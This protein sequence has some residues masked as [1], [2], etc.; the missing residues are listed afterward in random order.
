MIDAM[1][2]A[3]I[4]FFISY[5]SYR[6]Q[7]DIDTLSLGFSLVFSLMA[8]S[9]IQIYIQT[10]RID[11]SIVG[12][13]LL[14]FVVFLAFTLVFDVTCVACIPYESPYGVSYKTFRQ[15]RFWFANIFIIITAL[16]PRFTVKCFYNTLRNPLLLNNI[17]I[18]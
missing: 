10:T 12:S 4:I 8:T 7:S 16:L 13:T 6:N 14:S 3:T 1:W 2:Q 9:L 17:D 5:Y 18:P 11:W 15:G